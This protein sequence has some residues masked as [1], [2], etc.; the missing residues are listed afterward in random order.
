MAKSVVERFE[1][2]SLDTPERWT[3]E[4]TPWCR[5]SRDTGQVMLVTS[6]QVEAWLDKLDE[7][8]S[9]IRAGK[10]PRNLACLSNVAIAV[11]RMRGRF[12]HQPQAHRHYASRQADALRDILAPA[13]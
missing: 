1:F 8:R 10:L 6:D 13:F 11:V 12:E 9:R 5:R 2:R 4:F 3:E 7:D